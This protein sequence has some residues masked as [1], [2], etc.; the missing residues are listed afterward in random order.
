M[1][2]TRK[3]VGI[4][5]KRNGKMSR[6]VLRVN[7]PCSLLSYSSVSLGNLFVR[8]TL[9]TCAFFFSSKGFSVRH[10]YS[11]RVVLLCLAKEREVISKMNRWKH[12]DE[13]KILLG[14]EKWL[15]IACVL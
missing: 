3:V 6:A 5:R 8:T 7:F 14:T 13:R 1:V 15:S 11:V 4:L 10:S 12:I 2:L 9:F